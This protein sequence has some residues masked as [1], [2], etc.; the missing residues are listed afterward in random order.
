M[1]D[2]PKK[3]V[4]DIKDLKAKLG[5]AK[6]EARPAGE[7][8]ARPFPPPG[9]VAPGA[10]P[11]PA[12]MFAPPGAGPE[13]PPP[14]LGRPD[15]VAPVG[16]RPPPQPAARREPEEY[17]DDG[18]AIEGAE[19]HGKK[20]LIRSI[21]L[22]FMI[23]PG[24][25]IGCQCGRM[26]IFRGWYNKVTED[27]KKIK[28]K[29][30]T[31]NRVVRRMQALEQQHALVDNRGRRVD[32]YSPEFGQQ[33]EALVAP[34]DKLQEAEIFAIFYNMLAAK[35][36]GIVGQLFLY[37]A[38][39]KR[40]YVAVI[41]LRKFEGVASDFLALKTK[42]G[43]EE[44]AKKQ[45]KPQFGVYVPSNQAVIV[46]L[47][48]K[49]AVC[50]KKLKSECGKEKPQGYKINET[51]YSLDSSEKLEKRVILLNRGSSGQL[52]QYLDAAMGGQTEIV[53]RDGAWQI[54]LQYRGQIS[55][56]LAQIN[57]LRTSEI[58]KTYERYANRPKI[59]RYFI[60]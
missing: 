40:L 1:P 47:D 51:P 52:M 36:Q 22:G 32:T 44:F 28:T 45:T 13:I 18:T 21:V 48:P 10:V 19:V 50:G 17:I 29:L 3:G 41:A 35:D 34:L 16:Y 12:G 46:P 9:G 54:Y 31:V 53:Q 33:A 14:A 55:Q 20:A 15:V 4:R 43:A 39:L 59:R 23:I 24:F 25:F 57:T 7:E 8:A 5:L 49:N 42:K 58:L 37:F 60:F 56:I 11:P 6:P 38:L 26:G 2:K 30:T 27:S